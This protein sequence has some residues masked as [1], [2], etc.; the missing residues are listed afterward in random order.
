MW[1]D[2]QHPSRAV[3]DAAGSST[4]PSRAVGD[5]CR[6]LFLKLIFRF[7]GS[8]TTVTGI[9]DFFFQ[10]PFLQSITNTRFLMNY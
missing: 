8:V 9:L 4:S 7:R 1:L 10:V 5:A 6:A 2:H 3:G